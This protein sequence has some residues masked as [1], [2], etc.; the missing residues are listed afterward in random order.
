MSCSI[1]L[2][3]EPKLHFSFH[4]HC[5]YHYCV[6]PMAPQYIVYRNVL[7]QQQTWNVISSRF[8]KKLTMLHNTAYGNKKEVFTS[9]F[10]ASDNPLFLLVLNM[11]WGREDQGGQSLSHDGCYIPSSWTP[12]IFMARKEGARDLF[13]TA[14][15]SS[16]FYVKSRLDPYVVFF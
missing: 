15:F 13:T 6:L 11:N 2:M 14:I 8:S 3:I 4:D 7:R 16:E 12:R 10:I 9:I 5:R 1:E